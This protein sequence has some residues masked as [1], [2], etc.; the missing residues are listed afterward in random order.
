MYDSLSVKTIELDKVISEKESAYKLLKEKDDEMLRQL[1]LAHEIQEEIFP[2]IDKVINNYS[3]N[4]LTKAAS[5]VTGDVL[6]I[7]DNEEEYVDFVIA[8]V[9]GHG[10]PSALI[11]MMLKMSLQTRREEIKE[12]YGIVEA[13][14]NDMYPILSKATIFITLLFVRLYYNTGRIDIIDCGHVPP[15][16]IKNKGDIFLLDINGMMLGVTD[17][18]DVGTMSIT[19]E[20]GDTIFFITDGI[21]EA[22][23]SNSNFFEEKYFNILKDIKDKS[24]KEIIDILFEEIYKFTQSKELKDD[25]TI[26]GIRRN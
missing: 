9:T 14:K 2:N 15:I 13:V 18:L 25:A 11:T 5:I 16:I 3:I 19:I 17:E 26:L 6:S 10:V 4:S 24:V 1:Y 12:P 20:K 7:W 22:R 21:T 8:D 23:D